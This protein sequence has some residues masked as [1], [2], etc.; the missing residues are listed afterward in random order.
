MSVERRR[1]I[2][3]VAALTVFAAAGVFWLARMVVRETPEAEFVAGASQEPTVAASAESPATGIGTPRPEV[4]DNP[5]TRVTETVATRDTTT[6]RPRTSPTTRRPTT[7][8]TTTR[9]APPPPVPTHAIRV[10]GATLDNDSPRGWCAIFDN[11]KPGLT[12]LVTGVSVSGELKV[13][14]GKCRGDDNVKPR[15][16]CNDGIRIKPGKGCFAET[17]TDVEEPG[18]YRGTVQLSLRAE[19]TSTDPLACDIAV[20]RKSPPTKA[21]PAI[22]T[23]TDP[24]REVCYRVDP[25]EQEESDDHLCSGG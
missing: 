5:E 22:L 11:E 6:T 10:G 14:A 25:P 21:R 8:S 16:A 2:A 15:P 7:A 1:I 13:E 3:I 24:G 4:T 19:C 12:V 20:L 18:D 17:T 23:W 9:P